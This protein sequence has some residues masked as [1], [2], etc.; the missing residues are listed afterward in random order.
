MSKIT[1][2]LLSFNLSR[3][4]GNLTSCQLRKWHINRARTYSISNNITLALYCFQLPCPSFQQQRQVPVKIGLIK[5]SRLFSSVSEN[6]RKLKCSLYISKPSGTLIWVV[7]AKQNSISD[8]SFDYHNFFIGLNSIKLKGDLDSLPI[9]RVADRDPSLSQ[10]LFL[11][12]K[13]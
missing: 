10:L 6:L 13:I 7:C 4:W 12:L 9:Y 5:H 2:H 3:K 11:I 8:R 1:W